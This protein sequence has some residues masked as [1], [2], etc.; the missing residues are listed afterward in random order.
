MTTSK[1][2]VFT[3]THDM[4]LTVSDL[5][6]LLPKVESIKKINKNNDIYCF[7]CFD[8]EFSIC[9]KELRQRKLGSFQLPVLILEFSG[10]SNNEAVFKQFMNEFFKTFQRGGG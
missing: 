9:I 1:Q 6:R 4:S 7:L 3:E 8:K 5:E 2:A 10:Y